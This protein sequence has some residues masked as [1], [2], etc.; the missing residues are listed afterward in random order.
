MSRTDKS[1]RVDDFIRA[2]RKEMPSSQGQTEAPK[3]TYYHS[4]DV[5][6]NKVMEKLRERQPTADDKIR[7]AII[8]GEGHVLSMMPE[9][10]ERYDL[11]LFLDHDTN[12]LRWV[13]ACLVEVVKKGRVLDDTIK[14][15]TRKLEKFEKDQR[16]KFST[17]ILYTDSIDYQS[18]LICEMLDVGERNHFLNRYQKTQQAIAKLQYDLIPIDLKNKVKMRE[19]A[20]L[21]NDHNSIIQFI[22][23]TN[24]LDYPGAKDILASLE[25]LPIADDA[26]IVTSAINAKRSKIDYT[27]IGYKVF[28]SLVEF[29]DTFNPQYVFNYEPTSEFSRNSQ[30]QYDLVKGALNLHFNLGIRAATFCYTAAAAQ[31]VNFQFEGMSKTPLFINK[32]TN[33]F[34]VIMAALRKSS[35]DSDSL[36]KVVKR[37]GQQFGLSLVSVKDSQTKGSKSKTSFDGMFKDIFLSTQQKESRKDLSAK[38]QSTPADDVPKENPGGDAGEN[39]IC[40]FQSGFLKF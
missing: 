22:N 38:P 16:E 34:G 9:L 21:L 8:V 13:K 30:K 31:S 24:V 10:A 18:H 32:I 15:L 1:Q 19:L 35:D 33:L 7:V 14:L 39:P 36:N 37:I 3:M 28:N 23:I 25:L 4:N 40:G 5:D 12:V 26:L 20:K 2:R 27:Y 6:F 17:T 29:K 11:L